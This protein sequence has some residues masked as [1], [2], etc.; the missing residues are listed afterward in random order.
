MSQSRVHEF[1]RIYIYLFVRFC[2]V[3]CLRF[4]PILWLLR[5]F[6]HI[7]FTL[8]L[9]S[10]WI[11]CHAQ[12]SNFMLAFCYVTTVTMGCANSL[13]R[14]HHAERLLALRLRLFRFSEPI[15]AYQTITFTVYIFLS[16][17]FVSFPLQIQTIQYINIS[18]LTISSSMHA[19][20]FNLFLIFSHLQWYRK[21]AN[22]R[23]DDSNAVSAYRVY[24]PVANR[25]I[26]VRAA[27]YGPVVWIRIYIRIQHQ[28]D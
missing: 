6:V 13:L 4:V 11:L 10:A 2:L 7:H 22:T 9:A 27:W 24:W 28:M 26:H 16:F 25:S 1:E 19:K 18:F 5:R 17:F 8:S 3:P 21:H 20:S 15:F 14:S 12:T 23:V